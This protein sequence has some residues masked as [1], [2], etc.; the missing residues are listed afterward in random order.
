MCQQ[1][2]DGLGG[3]ERGWGCREECTQWEHYWLED[4]TLENMNLYGA[5]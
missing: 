3:C 5:G 4:R 1:H 2:S